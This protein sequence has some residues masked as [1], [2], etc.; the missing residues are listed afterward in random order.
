MDKE[1]KV[2]LINNLFSYDLKNSY[3]YF[4]YHNKEKLSSLGTLL[5]LLKLKL[6]SLR[7]KEIIAKRNLMEADKTGKDFY[8]RK[9]ES[10]IIEYTVKS[11][12]EYVEYI[13]VLQALITEKLDEDSYKSTRNQILMDILEYKIDMYRAS[14]FIGDVESYNKDKLDKVIAKNNLLDSKEIRE[15]FQIEIPTFT[16]GFTNDEL[17][18]MINS[19]YTL[20]KDRKTF[21]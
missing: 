17:E 1:L 15:Q 5:I 12:E 11:H 10:L 8:V 4:D 3:K 16:M 6:V 19:I 20:S 9:E 14:S 18:M 13:K 21:K 2:K 7:E